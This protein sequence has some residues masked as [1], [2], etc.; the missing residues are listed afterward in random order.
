MGRGG[1]GARINPV[2]SKGPPPSPPPTEQPCAEASLLR[3][4]GGMGGGRR[5]GRCGCGAARPGGGSRDPQRRSGAR[6]GGLESGTGGMRAGNGGRLEAGGGRRAGVPSVGPP[7][8]LLASLGCLCPHVLRCLP[9]PGAPLAGGEGAAWSPPGKWPSAPVLHRTQ[10]RKAVPA[11]TGASRWIWGIW[12]GPWGGCDP[13][14]CRGRAVRW[15]GCSP[16]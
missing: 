10:G 12:G 13:L 15:E 14:W 2:A 7:P 16:A 6:E 8:N 4:G 1:G 3:G 11:H 9:S 5:A